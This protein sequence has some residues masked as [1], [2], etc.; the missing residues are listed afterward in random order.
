[1]WVILIVGAIKK[2]TGLRKLAGP[3]TT[4]YTMRIEK[5]RT[6]IIET[7]LALK[8]K[9]GLN[10]SRS[11]SGKQYKHLTDELMRL[12]SFLNE[13]EPLSKRV[14]CLIHGISEKPSCAC[15]KHIIHWGWDVGFAKE[16][17]TCV[18]KNS[19]RIDKIKNTCLLR[20]GVSTNLQTHTVKEK[21]LAKHKSQNFSATMKKM[22]AEMPTSK[23]RDRQSKITQ[24][25][26]EKYGAENPFSSDSLVFDTVQ[27]N[28]KYAIMV[29]YGVDNVAKVPEIYNKGKQTRIELGY[30]R[31]PN[32]RSDAENYY[33]RVWEYTNRSFKEYYYEITKNDTLKR[34][35]EYHLDHIYSIH[36]GFINNIPPYIIGHK[37]NLR[38]LSALENSSKNKRCD[39]T[40]DDILRD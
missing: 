16:C 5:M 28:N 10:A 7:Y 32:Q 18:K 40:I 17:S 38:L 15:G 8:D 39:I 11:F 22:W 20:Y 25:N 3:P 33:S 13:K 27:K 31:H 34:G 21:R 4:H 2:P 14:Y 19:T 29:K 6:I 30:E 12:T 1:M 35:V 36:Y 37:N 9:F 23:I 26:L 24:T